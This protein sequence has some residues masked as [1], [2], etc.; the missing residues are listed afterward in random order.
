MYLLYFHN[1]SDS[2][3]QDNQRQTTTNDFVDGTE[4]PLL[5]TTT[6]HHVR[7]PA[8]GT[9]SLGEESIYLEPT[10]LGID[11]DDLVT[12]TNEEP[13]PEPAPISARVE[14]LDSMGSESSSGFNSEAS[15]ACER[16]ELPS[17]SERL[18]QFF[19]VFCFR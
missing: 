19:L 10:E 16:D 5:A 4:K 1:I 2:A 17:F 3:P 7:S 13:V 9:M 18:A 12:M 6:A 11:G 15:S 8:E 14:K